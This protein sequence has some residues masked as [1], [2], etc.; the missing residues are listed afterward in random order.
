MADAPPPPPPPPPAQLHPPPPP[1]QQPIPPP[2]PPHRAGG[3]SLPHPSA[4]DSAINEASTEARKKKRGRDDYYDDANSW[5]TLAAKDDLTIMVRQLHSK[6]TEY[7]VFELFSKAG[8]VTDVRL[9]ND[10][11][12]GRCVG[13]GY[14][15]MAA[16][17]DVPKALAL[18]GA[19]LCDSVIVVQN[20]LAE[21]NRL[22]SLG[23][24][25]A[26][27]RHAAPG[28]F[29]KDAER[30]AATKLYVGGVDYTITQETL[31]QI[32]SSFG[33]IERVDLHK[34]S[35]GGSKGFGFV[36]FRNGDDGKKAVEQMDGFS[37][38]GR[39]IR[40]SVSQDKG[41]SIGTTAVGLLGTGQ[42]PPPPPPMLGMGGA[43]GAPAPHTGYGAAMSAAGALKDGDAGS[44]DGLG[45]SN[46]ERSSDT[47]RVS[48][49]Q[50]ASIMTKLAAGAGVEVPDETRKAAQKAGYD[51][52]TGTS[53][54]IILKN[55]FDRLSA[56][57][58]S[59]AR[60]FEE[61]SADVRTEAAKQGTVLAC[62][63]DKWS[64]GFVYIKMLTHQ[65]TMRLRDVM[66]GRYFAK[67]RIHTAYVD[68]VEFDK[69]IRSIARMK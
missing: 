19:S 43:L 7:D 41:G 67:N 46:D 66:E 10:A 26:E 52:P 30:I 45:G 62:S 16:K 50:R 11:K 36:Y 14:V 65:E 31:M 48:A 21:R 20:S 40:V 32:F 63:A 25:A 24:T 1:Q 60:Y 13:S 49:A 61:L 53:R 12:S 18:N 51:Q 6:T 44:L 29:Q 38:A 28:Q 33:P 23:A 34:D 35:A 39:P 3:P 64:N 15:E 58:T 9:I 22:S 55:M 2:P 59:N 56:E 69:K 68:E 37:I 17:E 27:I 54:C 4:L 5:E 57:A 47:I 42:P 8:K